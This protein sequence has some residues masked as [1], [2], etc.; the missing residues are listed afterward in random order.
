MVKKAYEEVSVSL[1]C[2]TKQLLKLQAVSQEKEN[3]TSLK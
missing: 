3:A 2:L 1:A